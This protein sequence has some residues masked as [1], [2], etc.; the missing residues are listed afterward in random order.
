LAAPL[1]ARQAGARDDLLGWRHGALVKWDAV[2]DDPRVER[3]IDGQ[4]RRIGTQAEVAWIERGRTPGLGITSMIPPVFVAYATL[5]LP[6]CEWTMTET[7]SSGSCWATDEDQRRSERAFVSVLDRHAAAAGT[8]WLGYL[9]YAVDADTVVTDVPMVSL[10]ADWPY[11]FIEAGPREAV[12]R[13]S[14]KRGN[15]QCALPDVMFPADKA[16]LV[17]LDWDSPWYSIGGPAD[18]VR[19]LVHHQEL[20]ALAA[21]VTA[22]QVDAT[23]VR[24][25]RGSTR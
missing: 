3:F 23:P 20:A 24:F 13:R 1:A 17:S 18:L 14:R 25:Q 7:G 21:V 15:W 4:S 2:G 19:D 9:D 11:V 22:E 16:W 8:W 5:A 6:G 10:Y 12:S